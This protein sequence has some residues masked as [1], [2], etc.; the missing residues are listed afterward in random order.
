MK[1]QS[2]TGVAVL[3]EIAE[4]LTIRLPMM[5]AEDPV[6]PHLERFAALLVPLR[7]AP[8]RPLIPTPR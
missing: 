8:Q 2:V 5:S 4:L 3:E 7:L 1:E 6:R